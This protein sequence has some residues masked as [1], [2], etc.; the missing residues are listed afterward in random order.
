[1]ALLWACGTEG[2]KHG[3]PPVAE[4]D[5][6]ERKPLP[7]TDAEFMQVGEDLSN[8]AMATLIAQV[9][10]HMQKGGTAEA[11]PYCH[12]HALP[13]IDSLSRAY[14]VKLRRTSLKP[15]NMG[16][17]PDSLELQVLNTWN[18]EGKAQPRLLR[19]A[20]AVHYLR[21][22]YIQNPACLKCHGQN[23]DPTTRILLKQHYP[24][25]K[26]TGYAAGDLRGA[27]HLTWELST[28]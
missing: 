7:Q 14:G 21:P 19:T 28:Q 2:P 6:P 20:T 26:A 25:D 9:T 17:I 16:N 3:A 8:A 18:A 5:M 4:A 13:L 15:R 23:L 1:M 12:E 11:L 27:W 22:I 24:Q 10:S